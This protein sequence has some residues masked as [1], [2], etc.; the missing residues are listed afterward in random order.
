MFEPRK[1]VDLYLQMKKETQKY[2]YQYVRVDSVLD[3]ICDSL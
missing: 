2:S 1:N 3:S